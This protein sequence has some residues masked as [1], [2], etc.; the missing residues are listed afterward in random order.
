[1]KAPANPLSALDRKL[2]AL[3]RLEI[4]FVL[5]TMKAGT[6]WVQLLLDAHPE[7][8]CRGEGHFTSYLAPRLE[9]ALGEYNRIIASKNRDIFTNLPDFPLLEKSHLL[10]LLRTATSLLLAELADGAPVKWVGEKSPNNVRGLDL[11]GALF[12]AAR[13]V[14][15]V[16]DLRDVAV[17]GWF[18]N[19]RVSP[20]WT[21]EHFKDID[22]YALTNLPEWSAELRLARR[23][24]AAH[25]E[26]MISVRYEDLLEAPA[27]NLGRVLDFLGAR[28]DEQILEA[29]RKAASFETL[30]GG[31]QRGDEDRG[32]HFRKGLAG[33]GRRTLAPATLERF[34]MAAGPEMRA[35]GYGC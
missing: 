23:F 10:Y 3:S 25:P 4:F 16:R 1:M 20:Q 30:S 26:R 18:H 31:R 9:Q 27:A 17:S 32:S 11:L 35:F 21:E 13:F 24:A 29:C 7:I 33:E 22:H 6:T 12:P 2:D 34:E 8:C 5:G 14:H 19:L 28:K 15:V